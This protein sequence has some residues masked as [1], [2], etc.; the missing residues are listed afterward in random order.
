MQR[1]SQLLALL[2]KT[3]LTIDRKNA[4]AQQAN[5]TRA[6]FA[7]CPINRILAARAL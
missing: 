5:I 6:D 2:K 3:S 1:R 4:I 7:H